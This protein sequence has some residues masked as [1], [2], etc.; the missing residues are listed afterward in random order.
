LPTTSQQEIELKTKHDIDR[1]ED[2]RFNSHLASLAEEAR[3]YKE[4]L[5][6]RKHQN[7]Q[8][9]WSLIQESYSK[10]TPDFG[11]GY[12]KSSKFS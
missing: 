12:S 5:K 10:T 7:Q 1:I 2:D 3:K 8:Q 9:F 6:N 4:S 11:K